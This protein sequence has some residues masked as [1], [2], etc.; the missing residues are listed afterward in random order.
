[1]GTTVMYGLWGCYIWRDKWHRRG[2]PTWRVQHR[3]LG[4]QDVVASGLGVVGYR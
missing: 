3:A 4:L 1:M 2:T